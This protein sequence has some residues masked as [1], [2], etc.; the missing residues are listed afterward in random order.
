MASNIDAL[1]RA[2][3]MALEKLQGKR[4]YAYDLNDRLQK[5]A[6]DYRSDTVIQAMARVVENVSVKNPHQI[7]SQA[8]I[9]E[10]YNEVVGLNA[11]GTKCREV[12]GDLFVSQQTPQAS[13]NAAYINSLRHDPSQGEISFDVDKKTQNELD[14]LFVAPQKTY[15]QNMAANAKRKVEMELVSLGFSKPRISLAGGNTQFVVF[16][17]DLDTTCGKVR[18]LVPTEATGDKLPTV[19]MADD[20]IEDLTRDNINKYLDKSVDRFNHLPVQAILDDVEMPKVKMPEPLKMIASD[21][22]EKVFETALG[23]P[24]KS[25][26]VAKKMVLSE[27]HNM[28]FKGS[29]IRVSE[30]TKDGFICQATINTTNGKA[31]VEIPIEMNGQVPLMPSV[32]ASGDYIADFNEQNL[33]AFALG[34]KDDGGF[35]QRDCQLYSMDLYQLKDIIVKAA[36]KEDFETCNDALDVIADMVD[37]N[38]YRNVVSDYHKMLT[39]LKNGKET[40]QQAYNDSDQF[41]K[42]PNSIYPIHKKFGRPAHELVRDEQGNYHL[43]STYYARQNQD[44][45]GAF[46]ST[47]KVLVGD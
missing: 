24:Q 3:Q 16:A 27:L 23:Y 44:S 30:P 34:S 31:I 22:E 43:K 5:A 46:F 21:L 6:I 12:L 35:I 10:L 8:E 33:K 4:Y 1:K 45:E 25:I 9:E 26:Q 36:I 29:Q 17:A 14:L 41:V 42:T 37:E 13:E 28:G 11:S 47:A 7:I 15:D 39:N 2:A 20:K 40:I 38:T 19:F 32:F 18:I